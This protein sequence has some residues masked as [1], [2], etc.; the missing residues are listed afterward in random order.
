MSRMARSTLQ[1][2][3]VLEQ[4]MTRGVT[5]HIAQQQMVLNGS[6]QSRIAAIVL[7]LAAEIERECISLRTTEAFAKRRAAGKPLGRPRGSL[8]PRVKPDAKA[9]ELRR[10]LVLGLSKRAIARLVRCSP[11]TLYD[12][13]TRRRVCVGPGVSHEEEA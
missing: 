7:G 6:M 4:C 13:L 3:E 2:L 10:Y 9:E 11:T 8:V 5:V 1:V 12:W